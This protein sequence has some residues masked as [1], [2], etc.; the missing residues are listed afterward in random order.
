VFMRSQ[1]KRRLT[2]LT[3]IATAAF[4]PA[5]LAM[6]IEAGGASVPVTPPV[7]VTHATQSVLGPT[8]ASSGGY[9]FVPSAVHQTALGPTDASSGGYAFVPSAVPA[10]AQPGTGFQWDDAGIG[11]A[12]MVALI[13]AG[14]VA[15]MSIRRRRVRQIATS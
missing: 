1:I 2:V 15:S 10:T 8:D 12:G 11:A 3:V 13:G 5:A 7:T 14:A 6:P 9:A 4:P